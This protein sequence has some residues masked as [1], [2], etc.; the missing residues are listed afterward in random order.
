MNPAYS[1]LGYTVVRFDFAYAEQVLNLCMREGIV[2]LDGGSDG[3]CLRLCLRSGHG[4][5]LCS[6]LAQANV[7]FYIEK[8]GGL[9][10]LLRRL[11]RRPGL[12]M[13]AL[14]ALALIVASECFV[15]DIRVSGNSTL[16]EREIKELL[17]AQGLAKGAFIPGLDTDRLENRV[18]LS[19]DKIAWLSVNVRGNVANV[20]LIEQRLPEPKPVLKPA[21]VVA[22]HS[23]EV[24]AVEL[25]RG[26][27]LVSAG[28]QVAKG[29]ILIAG[30]Y[31]SAATGFRFTRAA[32]K[33]MARTVYSFRVEVA[34]EYQKKVYTGEAFDKKSLNFFSFPIK[35]FESTGNCGTVYDII[36]IVENCSPV[37]GV[38]L[39]LEI[40]TERYL[41]YTL[42]KA[43]RDPEAALTL[44]HR[45]LTEQI[46]AALADG[47]LLEK[48]IYT[49]IGESS[50]VLRADVVC[51]A[52]IAAVQEFEVDI[53]KEAKG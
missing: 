45:Q 5:R 22:A 49:E 52:D 50:V 21:H 19:S 7:P 33:V 17:S 29:E 40:C 27:V 53:K 20:E 37:P 15:F 48:H 25:Y 9:P 4:R 13:G 11:L 47:E 34:Y 42:E 10:Q 2:Y 23:G 3:T 16:T 30:V 26:N 41:P 1:I 44:A 8:R 43:Y 35:L 32:G 24:V 36:D 28:E 51:I 38:D 6:L 12:L 14:C 46:E 18:M 39:P 31:D